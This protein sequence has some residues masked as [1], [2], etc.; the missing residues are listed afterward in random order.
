MKKKATQTNNVSPKLIKL[1]EQL[2]QLFG[3]QMY[4]RSIY[5]EKRDKKSNEAC[6]AEIETHED[7]QR[8]YIT[9]YPKFFTNSLNHQRNYVLHEFCHYF[10]S[11]LLQCADSLRSG[12]FVT[13]EQV[14][15]A[16]EKCTSRAANVIEC[17]MLGRGKKESATFVRFAKKR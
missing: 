12:Q 9:L 4:D 6:V 13:P 7:Y 2:A 10:S 1:F 17:L 3:V 15:I 14:R 16:S 8:L 11:E 5:I